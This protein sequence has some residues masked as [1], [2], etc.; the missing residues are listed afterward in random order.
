MVIQGITCHCDRIDSINIIHKAVPVIINTIT[1]CFSRILPQISHKI[2]VVVV[3]TRID[4]CDNDAGRSCGDIPSCRGIDIHIR[5]SPV[6]AGV[7]KPPEIC[8]LR[9]IG[10]VVINMTLE[11]GRDRLYLRES[12]HL[13]KHLLGRSVGRF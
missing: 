9:I 1:R 8:E 12:F 7:V 10:N 3:N 4:D 6:L 2:R 11:I 5:D 13:L